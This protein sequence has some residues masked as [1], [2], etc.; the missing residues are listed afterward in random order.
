MN[1][2]EIA[3]GIVLLIASIIIITIIMLQETKQADGMNAV[4]GGARD[5]YIG[6]NG[7]RTKDA[8]YAKLTKIVAV[9]FFIIVIVLNL[10]VKFIK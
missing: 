2:F 4:T 10:L 6:R 1:A 5:T 9:V 3:G 7:N 8:F